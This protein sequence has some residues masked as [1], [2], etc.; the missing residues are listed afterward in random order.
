MA[1]ARASA[2]TA[3]A[4]HRVP[5][6]FCPRCRRGSGVQRCSAP[7]AAI[8]ALPLKR[9]PRD[10]LPGLASSATHSSAEGTWGA[11]ADASALRRPAILAV[12]PLAL[13]PPAGLVTCLTPGYGALDPREAMAARAAGVSAGPPL[14]EAAL[15]S[16][17][18]A[19][20]APVGLARAP[21]T[22]RAA[23][24]D[25]AAPDTALPG[26]GVAIDRAGLTL[27]CDTPAAA[28]AEPCCWDC[29]IEGLFGA[30]ATPLPNPRALASAFAL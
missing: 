21:G 18:A 29:A 17:A 6:R 14:A 15:A 13:T 16:P 20:P 8:S 9:N 25:A 3:E 12:S 26:P 4:G 2:D 28:A 11:L 5:C 7:R 19:A 23:A 1:P 27:A 30:A 22:G 10:E 24:A